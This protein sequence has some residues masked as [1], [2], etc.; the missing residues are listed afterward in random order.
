MFSN[1]LIFLVAAILVC[2]SAFSQFIYKIKTDSLLVTNDSC[3]AELNLENSTRLVN[4]FLYNKG[5]GR[6]EFRK[7]MIKVND[8]MYIIGNDTLKI[9]LGTPLSFRNGLSTKNN[10]IEWGAD[11]LSVYSPLSSFS[12]PTVLNQNGYPFQWNTGY[13]QL[14]VTNVAYTPYNQTLPLSD[15]IPFRVSHDL[16][17]FVYFENNFRMPGSGWGG[18]TFGLLF[19]NRDPYAQKFSYFGQSLT[20]SIIMESLANG[21]GGLVDIPALSLSLAGDTLAGGAATLI[22]TGITRYGRHRLPTLVANY[23]FSIGGG[24]TPYS[25]GTTYPYTRFFANANNVPFVWKNLPWSNATNGVDTL[26]SIDYD[27][28][29]RQKRLPQILSASAT[30]DFGSTNAGA[31][32]DMTITVA[33]AVDGDVVSIGVPHLAV[34]PNSCYTAWVSAVNTVTIRF[35]NYSNTS[36]DPSPG[37]FKVKVSK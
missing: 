28:N 27:G 16:Q 6:T 24:N 13:N 21:A 35:N 22:G 37:T 15:Y 12:R 18:P 2:Q 32:N 9:P 5:N 4:G 20:G 17:G 19:G 33:G 14:H 7:G 29:V 26:L 3:N 8:S 11:T 1:K 25:E 10:I 31:S 30:I 34:N 36:I 23:R